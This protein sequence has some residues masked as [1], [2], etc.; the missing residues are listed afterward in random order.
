MKS[1]IATEYSNGI[2]HQELFAPKV[3]IKF[4][5]DSKVVEGMINFNR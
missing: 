4:V 2:S 1:V 5:P 3:T